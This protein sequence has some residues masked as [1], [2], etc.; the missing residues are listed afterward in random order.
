MEHR[1]GLGSGI[2][3]RNIIIIIISPTSNFNLKGAITITVPVY[4]RAL[5]PKV[6]SHGLLTKPDEPPDRFPRGLSSTGKS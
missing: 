1:T 3:I 5:Q 6:I 4:D 2:H